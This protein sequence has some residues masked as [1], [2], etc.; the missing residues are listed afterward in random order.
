MDSTLA[1]ISHDTKGNARVAKNYQDIPL[2]QCR[3][4]EIN[5]VFM[6]ILMN[7]FQAMGGEGTLNVRVRSQDERVSV[8]ITDTGEGMNKEQQETLFDIGFG[9]K[10]GRIGMG[11]G[12]PTAKSIIDKHGGALSVESEPGRGTTFHISLPV[13]GIQ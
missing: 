2:I 12:L 11:L 4:K 5:Q 13:R 6:T 9:A 1:L 3:P 7:A 8:G 10:Q